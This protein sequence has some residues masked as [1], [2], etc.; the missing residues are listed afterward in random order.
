MAR[1]AGRTRSEHRSRGRGIGKR[2]KQARLASGMS[3]RQLAKGTRMSGAYV[4]RI[5]AGQRTPSVDALRVFAARLGVSVHWLETG[6][7]SVEITLSRKTAERLLAREY[8]REPE[9]TAALMQ[10]L[11]ETVGG[12]A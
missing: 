9:L 12:L 3:Q 7:D 2:L 8:V 5:E 4:S 11:G 1:I 10:A 6:E